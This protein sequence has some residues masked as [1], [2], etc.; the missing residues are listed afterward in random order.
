[1]ENSERP[2]VIFVV[3][4]FALAIYLRTTFL[5]YLNLQEMSY[6]W[7]PQE[8]LSAIMIGLA[9]IAFSVLLATTY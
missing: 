3:L 9:A 5:G 2:I 1:V 6:A 8:T 7:M 4:Q